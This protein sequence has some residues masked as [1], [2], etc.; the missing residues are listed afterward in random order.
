MLSRP[1]RQA[2][3][4]VSA[5]KTGGGRSS[6][7]A[8]LRWLLTF[9]VGAGTAFTAIFI[10]TG[11]R[12]L[13]KWKFAVVKAVMAKELSDELPSGLAFL[14]FLALAFFLVLLA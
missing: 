4:P 13:T 10:T 1:R 8:G 3:R 6:R 7:R 5:P 14:V 11:A 2:T 9:C 12:N